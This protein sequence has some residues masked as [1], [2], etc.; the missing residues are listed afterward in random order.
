MCTGTRR[1]RRWVE[2]VVLVLA[3]SLS[4]AANA[5]AQATNTASPQ[6]YVLAKL[7]SHSVVLVGEAHW[8]RQDAE[9][10]AN[11][12]DSLPSHNLHA[13]AV[14]WIPA[15]EQPSLD[16]LISDDH[17]DPARA[18]RSLRAG[19]WPYQE[20]LEVLHAAWRANRR[21]GQK[22]VRLFALGPGDDWR[23]RLLPI[24]KSYETF[25]ADSIVGLL[26]AGHRPLLVSLGMHHAFTRHYLPDLPER[27][28]TAVQSFTDR[29]GN[30]LR[31]NLGERVFQ[32]AQA[33]PWT[34]WD[35]TSW[36]KCLPL[37]G[38]IDCAMNGQPRP[39]A[40]DIATSQWRD[41]FIRHEYWFALGYAN[42]RFSDLAD[43]Y[44]WQGPVE[45]LQ[46]VRLIPLNEFAPDSAS[47]ASLIKNP[48]FGEL[49]EQNEAA[50]KGLW[51]DEASRLGDV[52][53]ARGWNGLKDWRSQCRNLPN[54][55]SR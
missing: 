9:L 26:K 43:G 7:A 36:K 30:V 25:M 12:V 55:G 29:T 48:P 39:I 6:M 35:G 22:P 40:F 42:V 47:L 5:R 23:Q 27:F 3:C 2:A 16:T 52:M 24:G 13:V 46:N 21:S 32:I 17:W 28:G 33:Y 34:C 18:I 8:I 54:H 19:A 51:Q 45:S 4:I 14:E 44:V 31:R 50:L 38:A 15:S 53:T 1:T 11:V 10:F 37:D 49:K 20:Y 41:T